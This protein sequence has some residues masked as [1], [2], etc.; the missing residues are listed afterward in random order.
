MG[1]TD[2]KTDSASYCHLFV[3]SRLC[4]FV[5]NKSLL[6]AINLDSKILIKRED[7]KRWNLLRGFFMSLCLN[8]SQMRYK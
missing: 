7:A 5:F 1:C 8:Y 2:V 6:T 4:A 3:S